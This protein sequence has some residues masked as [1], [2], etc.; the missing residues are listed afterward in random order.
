MRTIIDLVVTEP[1]GG[2]IAFKKE[3]DLPFALQAGMNIEDPVWKS[4]KP[5]VSVSYNLEDECLHVAMG[6][7]NPSDQ[8]TYEQIIKMY[9]AHG[10]LE[11][12]DGD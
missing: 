2:G 12:G 9:K 10:W 7:V 11:V 4:E 5:I 8:E 3:C 1:G 6:L